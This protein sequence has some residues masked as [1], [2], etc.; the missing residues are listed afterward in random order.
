M[1]LFGNAGRPRVGR[2][3]ESFEP[4]S[5]AKAEKARAQARKKAD[6]ARTKA[7]REYEKS[8][9]SGDRRTTQPDRPLMLQSRPRPA[10]YRARNEEVQV[11]AAAVRRKPSL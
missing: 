4:I 8:S 5:D 6:S 2:N 9:A 3:T 10:P 1:K 11:D 7:Y